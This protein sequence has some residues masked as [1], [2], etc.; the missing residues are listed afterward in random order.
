PETLC[1]YCDAPLPESPS[2]LLLRLLEQTAAKSVRAPRPRNPLGRKAALGIYVT[3]CQR[4][5]FESE[6]L[7]EAEKKGWPKD[8]NWKAIEGRVKNMREDL[9]ALL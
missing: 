3:V 7:P 6:V 4:H 1:P 2:P 9:Q 8:I 5:R